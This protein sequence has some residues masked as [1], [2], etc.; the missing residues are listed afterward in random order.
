MIGAGGAVI[1]RE[2]HPPLTHGSSDAEALENHRFGCDEALAGHIGNDE[3]IFPRLDV[4]AD[5]LEAEP[6]GIG[7]RL[8]QVLRLEAKERRMR[9]EVLRFVV[10]R[11]TIRAHDC[12]LDSHRAG[13]GSPDESRDR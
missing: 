8:A 1:A 3:R 2:S 5:E 9:P 4:Q 6:V 13:S 12:R 7:E 11:F 10:D